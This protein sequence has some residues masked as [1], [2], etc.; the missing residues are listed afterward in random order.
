MRSQTSSSA[1]SCETEKYQTPQGSWNLLERR[2]SKMRRHHGAV[3]LSTA[4][5]GSMKSGKG[6][7]QGTISTMP[8]QVH[9]ANL[10]PRAILA[11]SFRSQLAWLGRR[12]GRRGNRGLGMVTPLM[13]VA[14]EASRGPR[15]LCHAADAL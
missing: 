9:V 13:T 10:G 15:R 7:F 1:A 11:A 8:C 5:S 6:Q 14:A 4:P 12:E 2:A 3:A